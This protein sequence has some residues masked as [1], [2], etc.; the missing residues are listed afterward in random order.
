[1][2]TILDGFRLLSLTILADSNDFSFADIGSVH[3]IG[4]FCFALLNGLGGYNI[5]YFADLDGLV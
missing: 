3:W 1:M 4:W 5:F 2:M